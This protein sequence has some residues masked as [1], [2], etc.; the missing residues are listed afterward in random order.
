MIGR[1]ESRRAPALHSVAAF[2]FPSIGPLGELALVLILVAVSTE[3]MRNCSFEIAILMTTHACHF[4][5][6]ALQ[7]KLRL[8]V[9]ESRRET[10]LLPC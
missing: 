2:T 4:S 7:R 5:V 3:V 10:R 9:I 1:N 6:L 8:R